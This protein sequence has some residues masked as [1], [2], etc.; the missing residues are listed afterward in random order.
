MSTSDK[1][2]LRRSARNYLLFAVFCGI[3]S[4]VYE[5]FSHG[6]YSPFMV[7]LFG[8]PLLGAA[9]PWLISLI[10]R[11]APSRTVCAL[12]GC[13]VATLSAGCCL[14][15]VFDIYGGSAPLLWVYWIAGGVFVLAAIFKKLAV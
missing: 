10:G 12:W 7:C 8:I 11:R 5:H 13:G 3:F 6:V 14:R 1:Q 9:A 15:G 4:T 2:A